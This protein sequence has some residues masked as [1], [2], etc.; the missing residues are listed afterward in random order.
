MVAKLSSVR[1]RSAALRATSVPSFP[2]A[3]PTSAA[4]KD[5]ASLTPSPVIATVLPRDF[6]ASTIRTLCSGETLAKTRMDS[7]RFTKSLL[8]DSSISAPVMHWLLSVAIPKSFA[9]AK[10]VS[11]WSPVIMTVSTWAPLKLSTA[12]RASA[13]GGSIM[14]TSPTKTMFFSS[15]KSPLCF[16]AIASTR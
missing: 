4:F 12:P 3:I 16:T 14:P 2:I 15:F 7:T 8:S 5:G 1:T 11:T 10:A 9:M 13:L 6:N